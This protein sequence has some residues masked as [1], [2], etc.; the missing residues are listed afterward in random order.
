MPIMNDIKSNGLYQKGINQEISQAKIE[1][2]I[3]GSQ[4]VFQLNYWQIFQEFQLNKSPPFLRKRIFCKMKI[5]Q[6]L[7]VYEFS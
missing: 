6:V 3:K 2:I 4:L 1:M 5:K 7:Q